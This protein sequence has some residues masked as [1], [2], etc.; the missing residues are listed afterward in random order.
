MQHVHGGVA[1]GSGSPA[2]DAQIDALER[3][4]SKFNPEQWYRAG[5]IDLKDYPY[6]Y[7][8]ILNGM[9]FGPDGSLIVDRYDVGGFYSFVRQNDSEDGWQNRAIYVYLDAEHN[10]DIQFFQ[11]YARTAFQENCFIVASYSDRGEWTAVATSPIVRRDLFDSERSVD[12]GS[13]D[14]IGRSAVREAEET[15]Y[16]ILLGLDKNTRRPFPLFVLEKKA[17]YFSLE[18]GPMDR[19]DVQLRAGYMETEN[20]ATD[21]RRRCQEFFCDEFEPA[22]RRW[23]D[24]VT[25]ID[26]AN[27]AFT[28]SAEMVELF[29][30]AYSESKEM[31]LDANT[32]DQFRAALEHDWPECAEVERCVG[33]AEDGIGALNDC[34]DTLVPSLAGTLD[35]WKELLAKAQKE[36]GP[37]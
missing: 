22:T 37:R 3:P 36:L 17:G 32:V 12:A 8:A 21:M 35:K 15:P 13:L 16:D 6:V 18:K 33:T 24:D 31:V 5:G 26:N 27:E 29:F 20:R 2:I 28:M 7:C 30:E 19:F 14:A 4:S 23:M 10:G 25:D 34:A 9:C 11:Y 1:V